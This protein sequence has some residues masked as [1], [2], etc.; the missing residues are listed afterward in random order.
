MLDNQFDLRPNETFLATVDQLVTHP[1]NMRRYYK[2]GD[3]LEMAA[4][5]VA[6][7]QSSP[8]GNMHSLLVIP[9]DPAAQLTFRRDRT[10]GL[11]HLVEGKLYPVD[12]NLR[13][14]SGATMLKA[15]CPPFKCEMV[16]QSTA[17]QLLS[18]TVANTVRY[19]PDIISEGLHYQRL[20][21][22]EGMSVAE[23]SQA[24]G[25]YEKRIY[26]ALQW[27]DEVDEPI[28]QLVAEGNLPQ[29]QRVRKALMSIPDSKARVL[30][31]QRMARDGSGIKEIE[32]AVT[33]FKQMSAEHARH[34]EREKH[35]IPMVGNAEQQA[36]TR[37]SERESKPVILKWEEVREATLAMCHV[38][39]IKNQKLQTI[40]D[41]AWILLTHSADETCRNCP[42][43]D[44]AYACRAC[45]GVEMLKRV[46]MTVEKSSDGTH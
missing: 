12:G 4:S 15:G 29:D 31:A 8:Y 30:L 24:T 28:R 37:I 22:Q 32:A 14:R 9:T 17:Q 26:D 20:R 27:V 45:P 1:Q 6:H 11:V 34:R 41:P 21:E 43:K 36:G 13:V 23:I 18:M 44:I 10:T 40:P 33:H 46:I 7:A 25:V 3:M 5:L 42:V 35:P 19:N 38:C 39:E 2:H 16:S